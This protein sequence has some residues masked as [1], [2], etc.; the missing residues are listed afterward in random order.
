VDAAEPR[1]VRDGFF[2][3][4]LQRVSKWGVTGWSNEFGALADDSPDGQPVVDGYGFERILDPGTLYRPQPDIPGVPRWLEKPGAKHRVF[5]M[6]WAAAEPPTT[7]SL[8]DLADIAMARRHELTPDDPVLA[9]LDAALD[10]LVATAGRLHAANVTLGFLQPDSV[11]I[12]TNH[13]G[14]ISVLLPDVG[15]AW[16]DTGGLYEPDWLANPQAELIF[17]RGARERNSEY[18]ARLKQPAD[19]KDLRAR[20]KEKAGEEIEDVKI[21]AR[22]IA[23]ILAG[24][25][26]TKRWCGAAKALL[27]LPGKDIAPDTAAPIWDDVIA[28]ALEGRVETFHDLGLRLGVAKPS[29]HFLYSP[30]VPP[31][32]GWAVLRRTGLVGVALAVLLVLFIFREVF[33]PLTVKA[34]YCPRVVENDPLHAK[35]VALAELEERAPVDET[36]RAEFGTL[37]HECRAAHAALER[38]SSD[39]LQKATDAYVEMR[40]AEGDAVLARLRAMPRAVEVE[41]AE[42]SRAIAAIEDAA[43]ESN[44][45]ANPSV[46]KK[47]ERQLTLR[48]GAAPEAVLRPEVEAGP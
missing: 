46:V 41:R 10:A 44:R 6:G 24:L 20:V 12:V 22:L 14:S 21:V 39:C 23:L 11:R 35:L 31:W 13:D 18:V 7:Q 40:L 19:E 9:K 27:Q 45:H 48:G 25:P 47:L 16:D 42:I 17:E 2:M 4:R 30:P 1:V 15:F 34:P 32:R 8:P 33:F 43:R 38:C 28:P 26:E 3:T 36:V 29:G 37:L 5:Q